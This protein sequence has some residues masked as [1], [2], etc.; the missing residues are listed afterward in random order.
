MIFSIDFNSDEALYMQ[1]CNQIIMCIANEQIKEGDSLPSVRQL[2]DSIGI[3]MHTVNKAYTVLRQ[4][5]Y[6]KLDRR[7]GAIISLNEDKLRAMQ[8]L[9]DEMRVIVAKA[10]CKNISPDEI[11]AM[12]DE[13]INEITGE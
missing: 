3:N 10:V 4:E 2:A 11:H 12:V 13:V 8:E 7:H 9:S 1:L 6:I 5:G